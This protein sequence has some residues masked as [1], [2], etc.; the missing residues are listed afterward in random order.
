MVSIPVSVISSRLS[1]GLSARRNQLFLIP[2]ESNP[3]QE[4]VS[5]YAYARHNREHALHQGFIAA[6]L[7]PFPNA[8]ACAMATARHGDSSRLETARQRLLQHALKNG[9][10]KLDG[11]SKLALLSDPVAL[12]R[13]HALLWEQAEQHPL[14]RHAFSQ[15]IRQP[16]RLP[17]TQARLPLSPTS[18]PVAG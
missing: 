7:Q 11:P 13:L 4:L 8:L 10:K 16:A 9:P 5:T 2:E 18:R 12:S 6:A 14:W 3:P 15:S 1:L 17:V